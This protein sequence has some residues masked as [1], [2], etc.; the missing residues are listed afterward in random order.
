MSWSAGSSNISNISSSSSSSLNTAAPQAWLGDFD[1]PQLVELVSEA[2][3]HN[4]NLQ[5]AA[6]RLDQSISQ[7]RISGANRLPE[8]GA[9]LNSQRQKIS[10]FGPNATGGV[11]FDNHNLGLNLSWELDLWGRLRNQSAAAIAQVEASQAELE[12]AY[13]SLAAQVCKRWFTYLEASQQLE[14]AESTERADA[15]NLNTLE[16]RFQ[17]GLSPG[18]DLR[19]MRVQRAAAQAQVASRQRLLDNAARTLEILLGRYPDATLVAARPALPALPRSI[20]AG[21]PSELLERRPDLIAAERQ[22]AAVDQELRAARKDRLPQISLTASGGSSSQEF[23]QL[24]DSDFSVWSLGTN[25]TQPLF[26]G[27]RIS[28]NIDRSQALLEQARAN[29]RATALQAFLEVE[30]S[31]AAETF[32]NTE[33][34]GLAQAAQE[35]DAAQ[36]LAWEQYR[37]GTSS[38]INT[39]DA[40]RSANETRSQLLR[41]RNS[42]LQ[43]RIDLYLALGGPFLS[44]S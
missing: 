24:L 37:Q 42:L 40:Q 5:A 8:L 32:L 34:A 7:A 3:D 6:A 41:L 44:A 15:A 19:R 13:L 10:S 14:L 43:N 11:R 18:L 2:L 20:P 9:R 30:S 39:L 31:L 12:G 33:Y 26:Q 27:G 25:L 16:S 38:F 22:L 1:S 35:A 29:Y 21:L 36:A 17:S 28:A 23:S 4:A